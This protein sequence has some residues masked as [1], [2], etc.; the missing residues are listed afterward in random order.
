MYVSFLLS[1]ESYF[2]SSCI[3]SNSNIVVIII[4]YKIIAINGIALWIIIALPSSSNSSNVNSSSIIIVIIFKSTIIIKFTIIKR[5]VQQ[6]I[7]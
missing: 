3:S 6:M 5:E 7:R 2:G 1:T 4:K